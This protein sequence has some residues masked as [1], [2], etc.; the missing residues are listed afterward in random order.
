MMVTIRKL[1]QDGAESFRYTGRVVS[2]GETWVQVEAFFGRDDV[3]IGHVVFRKGD[4]MIEWFYADRW[5]NVFEL[6]DVD[7]DRLKGW[8]CNITRPAIISTEEVSWPD[9]ALDVWIT[10]DGAL[11]VVDED[12]FEALALDPHTRGAVLAAVA[13][14]YEHVHRREA[15]FEGSDLGAA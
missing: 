6:R 8:Y 13:D 12:E 3:D 5:Y 1:T 15:P 9:L 4:R 10:P 11:T 14:L 2:R 7:D